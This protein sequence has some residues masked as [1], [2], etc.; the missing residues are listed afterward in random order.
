MSI[1][2][3]TIILYSDTFSKQYMDKHKHT[4]KK[5][6]EKEGRMEKTQTERNKDRKTERNKD[7]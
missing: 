7:R 6:R 3:I 5:D 2:S 4:K 1:R